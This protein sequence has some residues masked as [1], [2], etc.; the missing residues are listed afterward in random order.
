MAHPLPERINSTSAWVRKFSN[1]TQTV[2]RLLRLRFDDASFVTNVGVKPV[3][4]LRVKPSTTRRVTA[5]ARAFGITPWWMTFPHSTDQ[6]VVEHLDDLK[7]ALDDAPAEERPVGFD[8]DAENPHDSIGWGPSGVRLARPLLQAYW[9]MGFRS[10]HITF[11]IF[12]KGLRRQDRAL[13]DEAKALGFWVGVAPQGY[14][15]DDPSKTWDN[16]ELFRPGVMQNFVMDHMDPLI[17]AGLIDEFRMGGMFLHQN[18]PEPWPD[19]IEALRLAHDTAYD[20]GVRAW[21]YWTLGQCS[22]KDGAEDFIREAPFRQDENPYVFVPTAAPEDRKE[23][24]ME[25][26]RRFA[27]KGY[28]VGAIDGLVGPRTREMATAYRTA[29]AFVPDEW[30]SPRLT[31]LLDELGL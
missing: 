29:L 28:K 31:A 19:G 17:E 3:H 15:K 30:E 24:V 16:G 26:Q 22:S 23:K 5:R 14:S 6:Q 25:A 21:K 12:R 20:R 18:H 1:S 7:R 10:V 13:I 8:I 11:V 27:G 2:D 9:D 4:K